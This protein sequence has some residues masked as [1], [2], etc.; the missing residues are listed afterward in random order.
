MAEPEPEAPTSVPGRAKAA[1][2]PRAQRAAAAERVAAAA[3]LRTIGARSRAPRKVDG[4][5]PIEASSTGRSYY[6][7]S[8]GEDPWVACGQDVPLGALGGSWTSQGRAPEGVASLADVFNAA[9]EAGLT[10]VRVVWD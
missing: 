1:A 10:F 6:L 4:P 9:N 5:F 8:R 2:K 3:E 7:F